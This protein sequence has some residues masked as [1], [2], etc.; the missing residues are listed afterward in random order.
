MA[1]AAEINLPENL[2]ITNIHPVH[3]L[4]EA[5]VDDQ[6]HDQIVIH[7]AAVQ[8][9]DT[10]GIQLLYAFAKAAKERQITLDWDQ[11]SAKLIS[12]AEIL[13]MKDSLGFH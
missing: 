13:G 6:T 12:A 1:N 3:E 10:A 2:T 8:R 4:L 7:A 11:P 9:A 5:M